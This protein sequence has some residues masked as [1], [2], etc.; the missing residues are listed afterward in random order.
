MNAVGVGTATISA[1]DPETGID[2][3]ASGG[4]ADLRGR[5]GADPDADVDGADADPD[6]HAATDGDRDAG[7]V[8]L[9]ITP[10]EVKRNVGQGQNFSV[11]GLYSNGDG[12]NLTQAATYLE[13]RPRRGAASERHQQQQGGDA[14]RRRRR[15]DDL[16]VVRRRHH[17]GNR[18]DAQFTVVVPPTPT[19]TRTGATPTPTFTAEPTATATPVLVSLALSPPAAKKGLG[20]FQNFVATGTFSDGSTRRISRSR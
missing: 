1:V 2:T 10:L 5:P 20:A 3:T 17:H 14:R 18:R 4:D 16:G 11:R 8:S 7:L 9:S 15:R 6:V 19:A 12:K 13:Q